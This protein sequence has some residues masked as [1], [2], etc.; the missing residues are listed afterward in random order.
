MNTVWLTFGAAA[1]YALVMAT[2]PVRESLRDGWR[3]LRRYPTLWLTLGLFGFGY[4]IFELAVRFYFYCALPAGDSPLFYWWRAPY[5]SEWNWYFGMR[6][7]LWHLPATALRE[8][9]ANA[10]FPALD[11]AAGL[12]NNLVST[13]PISALA[14][15]LLLCNLN[16]RQSVLWRA[17]RKRFG[18]WGVAA[19]LAILLC[20]LAA[21]GKPILYVL[22]QYNVNGHLWLRWSPVAAWLAF[23]F[24]Y[25]FGIY[26]QVYLILLAYCWVR[27][28]SFKREDLVDFAIRRSSFVLRWAVI[29]MLLS[30]ALIDLPLILK[31]FEVFASWFPAG[32]EEADHR[33][34]IARTV[35]DA[36]LL[37]FASIQITLTLH[38]ESLRKAFR[39]HGIFIWR[40]AWLFAWFL[41]IAALHF[42]LVQFVNLLVQNAAGEGSALWVG[43]QLFLPWL[44][45]MVG[46]WLLAAW[47][48]LF[49]RCDSGR[50]QTG[51][52]IHF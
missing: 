43:W 7:S 31:N 10:I 19:H 6:D 17:L 46:A 27:G 41:V 25:L 1:G 13:F 16:G 51:G 47:V 49:R 26:V 21:L 3:V 48:C 4:A 2:N 38:S 5:R 18:R 29:V 37:L 52:G 40:Q 45:G 33:L 11:S 30:S 14:A 36:I 23:L 22:P 20:A 34:K 12:F 24:E 15:L 42:Y 44:A 35:L 32:A 9:S 28:I 50:V 8:A 39:D